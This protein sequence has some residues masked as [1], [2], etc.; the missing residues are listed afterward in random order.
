MLDP[1]VYISH[2]RLLS[3]LLKQDNKSNKSSC[4]NATF[5]NN[6]QADSAKTLYALFHYIFYTCFV[7]ERNNIVK[8]QIYCPKMLTLQIQTLQEYLMQS[9]MTITVIFFPWGRN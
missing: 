9:F 2:V 3:D 1:F 4:S 8:R 6:Q 5:D 7:F